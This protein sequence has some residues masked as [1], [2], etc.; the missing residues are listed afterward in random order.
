LFPLIVRRAPVFA[1]FRVA[2]VPFSPLR[3][4][5]LDA[6]ATQPVFLA[7]IISDPP[8]KSNALPPDEREISPFSL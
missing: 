2:A 8:S 1:V 7:L 5:P 4:S 3:P 6:D